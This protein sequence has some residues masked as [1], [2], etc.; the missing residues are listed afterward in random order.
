MSEKRLFVAVDIS[1]AAREAISRVC[2][3]IP[4]YR[5]TRRD[6]LHLTLRFIGNINSAY[7]PELC[8]AL[9]DIEFSKLQ[10]TM[11]GTGFFRPSIFFL[12]LEQSPSLEALKRKVDSVLA[13]LLSMP[14]EQRDF[15]PHITLSR[16]KRRQN[17][18]KIERLENAFAPIFPMNFEVGAMTLY[19]SELT[20]GGAVHTVEGVFAAD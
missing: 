6:Q 12:D 4:E 14:K 20:P 8:S 19:A 15:V 7:I 16:F 5:W 10:L 13:D 2:R 11:T 9:S 1:D 3:G 18:R 17:R